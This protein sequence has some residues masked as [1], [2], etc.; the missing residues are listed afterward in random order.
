MSEANE[1]LAELSSDFEHTL[2]Q[3]TPE[4]WGGVMPVVMS[5]IRYTGI[6]SVDEIHIIYKGKII[7]VT[8]E[9]IGEHECEFLP[10]DFYCDDCDREMPE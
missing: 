1:L 3:S 2:D 5:P 6:D 9:I 10:P 8:G 4:D 7:R